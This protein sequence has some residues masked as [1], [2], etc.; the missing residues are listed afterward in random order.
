MG[1]RLVNLVLALALV[2]CLA[3]IVVSQPD[4]TRPNYEYL[5]EMA[6]SPAYSAF[7]ANPNFPDGMTL[8]SPVLGTVPRG[9]PPLHYQP[10]PEDALRAGEELVNP[11]PAS[12]IAATDRGHALFTNFCVPCHAVS[13]QGNGPVAARGFPP[14]PSLYVERAVNMRDGQMFHVLSFGQ[15]NMASYA[16]QISREDRWKVILYVRS[17]QDQ[18]A[19]KA[20]QLAVTAAATETNA[21]G[22]ANAAS[23]PSGS[24]AN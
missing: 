12:D 10:T 6:H 18:E 11:F 5:L 20:E 22:E 13:G 17:L 9:E 19:R 24:P 21:S 14:P 4:V 23:P 1:S 2:A 7:A 3:G 16:A 15:G 8:R